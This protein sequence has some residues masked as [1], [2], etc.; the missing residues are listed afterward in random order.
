MDAVLVG[1]VIVGAGL[2]SAR[3]SVFRGLRELVLGITNTGT[4]DRADAR[5]APTND[6]H[7][8]IS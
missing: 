2:A 1:V 4:P 7:L 6:R 3:N 8:T 5:P